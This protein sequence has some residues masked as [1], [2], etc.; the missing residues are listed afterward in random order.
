MAR[1]E[2]CSSIFEIDKDFPWNICNLCLHHLL[3][4]IK[5]KLGYK[6]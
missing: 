2:N 5:I 6:L 3:I 4:G 1:C